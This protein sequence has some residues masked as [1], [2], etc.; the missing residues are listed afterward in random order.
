MCSIGAS[1]ATCFV[2]P[3]AGWPTAALSLL[4]AMMPGLTSSLQR[5]LRLAYLF[6][7]IFSTAR[8]IVA[9]ALASGVGFGASRS[10]AA[11]G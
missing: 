2:F 1:L 9:G 3:L 4:S 7:V 8:L 10:S 11:K 6:L 5:R